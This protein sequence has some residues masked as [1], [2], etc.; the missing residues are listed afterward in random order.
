M[1]VQTASRPLIVGRQRLD[2]PATSTM[3]QER[4][5]ALTAISV[6]LFIL[7]CWIFDDGLLAP[8]LWNGENWISSPL[9]TYLLIAIILQCGWSQ[10][11]SIPERGLAFHL[12][13]VPAAA[14]LIN[15]PMKWRLLM[16]SIYYALIW[17]PMR[18]FL[19]R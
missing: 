17:L 8:P 19:G 18:F 11:R 16:G 14:G 13:R 4:S 7:L 5:W 10:A 3:T 1:E 12:E 9:L 6:V 15:D 2:R